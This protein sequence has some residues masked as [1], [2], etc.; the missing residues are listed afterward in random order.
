MLGCGVYSG[1]LFPQQTSNMLLDDA[2]VIARTD[3]GN[4][5]GSIATLP[6]QVGDAWRDASRIR[7]PARYRKATQVVVSGMGGS[8]LGAHLV[9]S[10]FSD[11]MKVPFSFVNGYKLP[12]SVNRKTI[13]ILSSYSGTTEETLACFKEAKKRGAMLMGITTGGPL[14]RMLRA[15]KAP[16]YIFKP[17]RN[18]SG[19]PRMG[20]GYMATGLIALLARAGV[21]RIP[22][23][24][25]RALPTRLSA[26]GARWAMNV[27][28]KRNQAK[29]MARTLA[30]K[31]PV[32]VAAEHLT[33]G[34]HIMQNQVQESAKQ[35]C[36]YFPLPELNH[37][38]MEG[39][40]FPLALK[41]LMTF[42]F[43]GSKL[44]SPRVWRRFDVTEMVVGK[45]G[46]D[47]HQ[48]IATEPTRL[49]QAFETLAFTSAV[50]FYLSMQNRVN[51]SNIP[52]VV[53]F[54][55]LLARG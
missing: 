45:Q 2:K 18:P 51:P 35:F 21:V 42:V 36:A 52:W 5:R 34:V 16:A 11:T 6:L 15:A 38:L 48:F 1:R 33:A 49:G 19:Q 41:K 29:L 37:H 20:L 24:E 26:I 30:G 53:F 12:G 3:T 10:V 40:K 32:L 55:K 47:F 8:T 43:I 50:S 44:Y 22:S 27:P 13:V 14:A 25:M 31:I 39:L 4:V 46:F 17:T 23:G 7:V 9:S 54:K 28:T